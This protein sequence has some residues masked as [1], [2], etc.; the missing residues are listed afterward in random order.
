MASFQVKI[1]WKMPRKRKNKNHRSVPFRSYTTHNKKFQ[2]NCKKVQKIKK[3]HYGFLSS[4][5]WL[6]KAEKEKK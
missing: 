6:E 4:Q 1:G 2:K 3:Y 5:N